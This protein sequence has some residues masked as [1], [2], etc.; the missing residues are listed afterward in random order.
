MACGGC[1]KRGQILKQAGA[2]LHPDDRAVP[3]HRPHGRGHLGRALGQPG[4][5]P[6]QPRQVLVVEDDLVIAIMAETM[7]QHLGCR[8]VVVAGAQ[9]GALEALRTQRFDFALLDVDLGDHDSGGVARELAALG[10]PAVVT[11]GYSD[12]DE[13]PEALRGLPR[14]SKPYTEHEL[15]RAMAESLRRWR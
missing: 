15:E 13:L 7:L 12:T 8:S 2:A 11:T 9:V 10:V 14:V 6:V 1:A 5:F 3:V 4:E